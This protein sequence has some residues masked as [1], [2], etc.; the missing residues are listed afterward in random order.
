MRK[1]TNT[2]A[3]EG[4]ERAVRL[5][6]DHEDEHPFCWAVIRSLIQKIGCSGRTLLE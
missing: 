6:L 3:P 5:V 4:R 1:T 2:S